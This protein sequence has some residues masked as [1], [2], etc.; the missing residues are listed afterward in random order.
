MM[1]SGMLDWRRPVGLSGSAGRPAGRRA[2]S[3]LSRLAISSSGSIDPG[4]SSIPA[5]GSPTSAYRAGTVSIVYRSGTQSGT[6]SQSSGVDTR[7]SGVGRIEYAD[8]VVWS[9]AFW[10]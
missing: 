10:L 7:A 6:S 9:L 8:A 5:P 3:L 4:R 1:I 2:S